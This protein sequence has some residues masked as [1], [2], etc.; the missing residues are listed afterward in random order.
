MTTGGNPIERDGKSYEPF[1]DLKLAV[2]VAEATG[3]PLLLFG[4]PGSG[5][6]SLA[7]YIAYQDPGRRYYEHVV[8]AQTHARDLLWSFDAVRRLSDAQAT[9]TL[10]DN[11]NYVVP[12]VLWW[13][14]HRESASEFGTDPHPTWNDERADSDTTPV[15]LID[16]IDKADPD[17][18]NGLLVPIA[19]RSFPITDLDGG[20]SVKETQGKPCL[21]VITSNGE[22]DLP[23]AF[24][25]RCVVYRIPAH[26]PD[27]LRTITDLHFPTGGTGPELPD[28]I[29]RFLL[30]ELAEAEK[31][32]RNESRRAPS[33]AEFLDA[34]RACLEL[35]IDRQDHPDLAVLKALIFYKDKEKDPE[36]GTR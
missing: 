9:K 11:K 15:V 12:G 35:G 14:F 13:A 16:E 36:T 5:K 2:Q 1:G 23:Q 17:L 31:S 34:V 3:R 33:T 30:D 21:I 7:K 8:T 6:S 4:Q 26:T 28:D 18:P 24:L 20:V 27:Q 32:A 29:V 19:E 10:D 22:R 25:R